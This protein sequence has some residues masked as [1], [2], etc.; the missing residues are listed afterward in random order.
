MIAHL[1]VIANGAKPKQ[2]VNMLGMSPHVMLLRRHPSI[3][4]GCVVCF[5]GNSQN[6]QFQHF[7]LKGCLA[8]VEVLIF[9]HFGIQTFYGLNSCSG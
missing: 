1:D 5:E 9:L 3:V 8:A 2:M 4:W 6:T 7:T